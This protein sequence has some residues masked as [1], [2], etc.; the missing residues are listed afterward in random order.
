MLV[1]NHPQQ[2]TAIVIRRH[3]GIAVFVRL[4]PGRLTCERATEALF[5]ETWHEQ[6]GALAESL[7]RFLAH[8]EA[9]GATQ[10]ALRGLE[11]LRDRERNA[12]ASLF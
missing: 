9:F 3:G 11:R 5:R 8:A 7:A 12:V 10:E 4:K 6:R 2:E 1:C